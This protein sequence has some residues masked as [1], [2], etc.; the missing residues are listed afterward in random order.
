M[1]PV[2]F[3]GFRLSLQQTRLW[4]LQPQSQAYGTH[5]LI[6]LEGQVDPAIFLQVLQELVNRHAILR[7]SFQ[8]LAGMELPVQV[9]AARA[10]VCCPLINLEDLSEP[11]QTIRLSES[12]ATGQQEPRDLAQAQ[13][14]R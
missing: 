11:E 1:Q 10:E 12:L 4:S 5:C 8:V 2:T 6:L 13:I 9:V 3:K 14:V 7:T